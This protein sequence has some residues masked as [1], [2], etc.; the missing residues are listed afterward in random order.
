MD[1]RAAVPEDLGRLKGM[2]K[3]IVKK[4]D[5]DGIQIW[6]E[7]YPC[8][9]LESD[10]AGSRLYL[11]TEKD[12]PMAAFAL[13]ESNAGEGCVEW[14]DHNARALYL[15]RFGVN[16]CCLRRG[17]GSLMLERA[18]KTARDFGAE[19]L[20]LFVVDSNVPAALLYQ[21]SGFVKAEGVYYEVIDDELVLREIGY[22]VRL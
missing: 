17:V 1:Y 8:E 14:E 22:E 4:M 7:I 9:F 6:D 21:K 20:R 12:A 18:K 3:E 10:I 2:Y 11:M 19:Y 13:C 5:E 15:D 16:V